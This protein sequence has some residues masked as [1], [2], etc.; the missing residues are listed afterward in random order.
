M[1]AFSKENSSWI[2]GDFF[3]L[4]FHVLTKKTS[5]LL[6]VLQMLQKMCCTF[7]PEVW[8]VHY[9][10]LLWLPL[11]QYNLPSFN[12]KT[13]VTLI[14]GQKL[15]LWI[16]Q[17]FY[18][19]F[20]KQK[21]RHLKQN[22]THFTPLMASPIRR[23]EAKRARGTWTHDPGGRQQLARVA[24]LNIICKYRYCEFWIGL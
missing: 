14:M 24:K 15:F 13:C 4:S 7:L 17:T 16:H 9:E 3:L 5:R 6:A 10:L 18:L 8:K 2:R 21:R 23:H 20:S 12:L 11:E 22:W 19:A 1:A